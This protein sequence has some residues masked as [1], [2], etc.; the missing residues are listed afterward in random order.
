VVQIATNTRGAAGG[1]SITYSAGSTLDCAAQTMSV[2][3]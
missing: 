2:A 1:N 3:A